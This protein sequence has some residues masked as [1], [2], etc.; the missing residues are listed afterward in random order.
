MKSCVEGR[1]TNVTRWWNE[2]RR[3]MITSVV[4]E[5]EGYRTSEMV[6]IRGGLAVRFATLDGLYFTGWGEM[7]T[8]HVQPRVLRSNI[9]NFEFLWLNLWLCYLC[10]AVRCW[11]VW[12][13]TIWTMGVMCLGFNRGSIVHFSLDI[14]F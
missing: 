5:R 2:P 6:G 12:G 1:G 3:K 7:T 9:Y 4:R 8:A 13:V 10:P 11:N 14:D